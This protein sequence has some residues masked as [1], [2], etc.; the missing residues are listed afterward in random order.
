MRGWT[1]VWCSIFSAFLIQNVLFIKN[2]NTFENLKIYMFH[3]LYGCSSQNFNHYSYVLGV[4]FFLIICSII[5]MITFLIWSFFLFFLRRAKLDLSIL[6]ACRPFF[7]WSSSGLQSFRAFSKEWGDQQFQTVWQ[8]P[9]TI[10]DMGFP[11]TLYSVN[12]DA[13]TN[14]HIFCCKI[15][16]AEKIKH[17]PFLLRLFETTLD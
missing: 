15:E 3:D 14:F 6:L 10:W 13:T 4:I 5:L 11:L 8:S 16:N 7:T 12:Y 1:I 17:L 9:E 2:S